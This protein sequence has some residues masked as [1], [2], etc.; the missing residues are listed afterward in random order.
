MLLPVAFTAAQISDKILKIDVEAYRTG[1]QMGIKV[2]LA[3]ATAIDRI[4]FLY[5]SFGESEFRRIEMQLLGNIASGSIPANHLVPPFLEYYL[6]MYLRN[7]APEETYPAENPREHPLKIDLQGAG[8]RSDDAIIVLSPEEKES[9]TPDDLVISFSLLNADSSVDRTN[10]KTYLDGADISSSSVISDNLVVVSPPGGLA[11]GRHTVRVELFD[12]AGNSTHSASWGFSLKGMDFTEPIQTPSGWLTTSSLQAETRNEDIAGSTAPYNRLSVSAG[13]TYN[14]FRINGLLHVTNEETDRRQPQNRFY[15]GGESPWLRLAY[16]DHYPVFQELIMTGRRVR[17]FNGNLTLGFFNLD[18]SAGDVLRR[19]ESDTVNTFPTDSLAAEQSRD[20]LSAY[21]P[22]GQ[23]RWARLRYGT[24]SR[25]LLIVRPIFGK[26]EGAH[27]GFTY[28]KSKDDIGSVAYGRK[29]EEN[30][31]LGSD[32]S[33]PFDHRNVE[34]TAQAAFSAT[35]KDI[36]EGTFSDERIDSLYADYNQST[37]DNIRRVKDNFSRFITINENLV[38]LNFKNTPTLAY[39]GALAL[40]YFN[41]YFKFTYLRHGNNFESFG[42]SFVRTDIVGFNIAD[43]LRLVNNQLS[44]SAGLERLQDNTAE[45]KPATTT[46]TTGSVSASWFSRTDF[47][48]V[49]LAYLRAANSNDYS[50]TD[51]VLFAS[52]LV[53]DRINRV[54]VQVGKEFLLG[55]RHN[56]MFSVSTSSRDDGRPRWAKDIAHTNFDT[57]NTTVA[58]NDAITLSIPL[59]LFFSVATS[60]TS[61]HLSQSTDT[62]VAYTT[63]YGSAQ[64]KAVGNKLILNGSVSPTLGDIRRTLIDARAQY[65]FVPNLSLMG[66]LSL[67]FNKVGSNDVIWSLILRVDV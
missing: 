7:G 57:R 61:F 1:E 8:V 3:N 47:P 30:L 43:R 15:I 26:R 52:Y 53:D 19:I 12:R 51:S 50:S 5:R 66:Q 42:Q 41:N 44:L 24:F 60:S 58:L 27:F 39:E 46:S 35:N 17:G 62:T 59:E 23:N 63:L 31:V 32:L 65:Y 10:V 9:V 20:S 14:A 25:D 49:T 67:Y 4:E 37:R 29:P 56:A 36:T 11:G 54:L 21:G 64:Y 48:N 13:G 55:P 45:T 28:L 18:V 22:Y 40:N 38:P 16:G 6:T 33:L 2:E 34:I